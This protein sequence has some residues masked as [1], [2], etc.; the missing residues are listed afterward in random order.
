MKQVLS[1]RK[2][3]QGA[4]PRSADSP[5]EED[6]KTAPRVVY[7]TIV[8]SLEFVTLRMPCRVNASVFRTV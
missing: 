3:R 1:S 5:R 2:E 7:N 6:N 4:L 8:T